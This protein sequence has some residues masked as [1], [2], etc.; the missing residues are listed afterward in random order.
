[1]S[2]YANLSQTGSFPITLHD[3]E[4]SAISLLQFFKHESDNDGATLYVCS[5]HTSSVLNDYFTGH[6]NLLNKV[7]QVNLGQNITIFEPKHGPLH[8]LTGSDKISPTAILNATASLLVH[9]DLTLA[10]TKL[11]N[12]IVDV[13]QRL[14]GDISFKRYKQALGQCLELST[15]L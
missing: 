13:E 5:N 7:S 4:I 2:E 14:N 10:A 9:L 6:Y 8:Q 3:I 15:E 12:C 1:M 11:L